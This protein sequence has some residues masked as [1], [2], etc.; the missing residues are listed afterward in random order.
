MLLFLSCIFNEQNF[1]LLRRAILD[2][3]NRKATSTDVEMV[4]VRV[5]LVIAYAA[6][7]DTFV[8]FSSNGWILTFALSSTTVPK[9]PCIMHL[10]YADM[11]CQSFEE[12]MVR[13]LNK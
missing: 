9:P 2:R 1:F 8:S 13:A 5:F 7:T 11:L 3:K 12:I 6:E 4:D 10:C